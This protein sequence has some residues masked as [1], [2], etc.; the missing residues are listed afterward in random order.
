VQ[1]VMSLQV[2][3]HSERPLPPSP[4]PPTSPTCSFPPHIKF[5]PHSHKRAVT[6]ISLDHMFIF[7]SSAEI[8]QV[9]VLESSYDGL[10]LA[11]S[12]LQHESQPPSLV[13]PIHGKGTARKSTLP[14]ETYKEGQ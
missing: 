3:R 1:E 9:M 13:S 10:V 2:P 14:K 4:T 8:H 7:R 12:A 5:Q 11:R 6:A